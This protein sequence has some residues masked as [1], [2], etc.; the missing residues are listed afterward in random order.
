MTL[1]DTVTVRCVINSSEETGRQQGSFTVSHYT[2]KN[3]LFISHTEREENIN[4]RHNI[5]LLV[6]E[7]LMFECQGKH[8]DH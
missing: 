8:I 5:T 6:Q 3:S 1:L 4:G 2:D 7:T